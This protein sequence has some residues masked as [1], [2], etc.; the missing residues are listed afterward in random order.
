M[1]SP[2]GRIA[3]KQQPDGPR[4]QILPEQLDK[5]FPFHI[6]FDANLNIVQAGS[7]LQRICPDVRS[8]IELGALFVLIKKP[9]IQL[10]FVNIIQ[11]LSRLMLLKHRASGMQ[12]RGE[13]MAC[14]PP[15][16][17]TLMFL[18]SPW[19]LSTEEL[20]S[21]NLTFEDFPNHDPTLEILEVFQS[22]IIAQD[23]AMRLGDSMR[24]NLEKQILARTEE[25]RA[26]NERLQN[27]DRVR[28]K[29]LSTASHELRTPMTAISSFTDSMLEGV[30]GPLNPQQTMYLERIKYNTKR[31]TRIIN[32]LL[33]WSSLDLTKEEL[34]LQPLSIREIACHVV[35]NITVIAQK[36]GVAIDLQILEQLPPVLGD[37]DKLEQIFWNV[38]GN[39]IKFTARGGHVTISLE[40]NS[41]GWVQVCVA[42]TGCGIAPEHLPLVFN[43]FSKIPSTAQ[44]EQGAQLGLCITRSYV[45]M[46]RGRIWAES[47][48]GAGTRVFFT[49][50]YAE[51]D[52]PPVVVPPQT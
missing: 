49:L 17:D 27:H 31:L 33:D 43:E 15:S 50:P 24:R 7:S 12:L 10:T 34:T 5:V 30:V 36:R 37:R 47:A 45:T 28:T 26:T 48:L 11:H 23:D 2:V 18:G 52:L 35:D 42:D 16:Q 29:F 46:H 1:D 51:T 3:S 41:E 39:A 40:F 44:A 4:I 8:G 20:V 9:E 22:R 21:Y 32:Q 14:F 13:F 19:L 38:I 25:L 6:A